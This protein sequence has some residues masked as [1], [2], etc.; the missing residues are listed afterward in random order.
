MIDQHPDSKD[1]A[2]PSPAV[3]ACR[4]LHPQYNAYLTR[5]AELNTQR[6]LRP[7]EGTD[8]LTDERDEFRP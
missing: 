4:A 8:L 6:W 2:M 7:G 5:S 3:S 1:N